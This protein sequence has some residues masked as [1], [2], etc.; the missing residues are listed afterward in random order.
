MYFLKFVH[1]PKHA[2]DIR[3]ILYFLNSDFVFSDFVFLISSFVALPGVEK[4]AW[5]MYRQI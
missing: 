4:S 1:S 5:Q 3:C 2:E